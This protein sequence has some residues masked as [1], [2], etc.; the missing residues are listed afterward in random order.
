MEHPEGF[1]EC[2]CGLPMLR[3]KGDDV[4]ACAECDQGA[5]KKPEAAPWFLV[6]QHERQAKGEG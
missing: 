5:G 3:I 2:R 4:W 6:W 1:P